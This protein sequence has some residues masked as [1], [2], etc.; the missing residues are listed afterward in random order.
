M[1][2]RVERNPQLRGTKHRVAIEREVLVARGRSDGRTVLIVPEVKGTQ[3]TGITLL[4]VGS[5]TGC[6]PPV[7]RGRAAGLDR[8]Y[9]RLVD[10]VTE[11]EPASATTCWPR[12][13][14]S[15]C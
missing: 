13:R 15:T 14:W 6:R 10:S 4:H 3:T 7:A 5:P 11:T 8:R 12:S 9:D 1:P 2:S